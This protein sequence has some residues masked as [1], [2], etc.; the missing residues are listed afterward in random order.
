MPNDMMKVFSFDTG[1]E[2][3]LRQDDLKSARLPDRTASLL[4]SEDHPSVRLN[5]LF[6]AASLDRRILAFLKPE[7]QDKN[8]LIPARYH[9]I[10]REVQERLKKEAEKR[11]SGKGGDT[12]E[13][14][15]ELLEEEKELMV[16]L[17]T[18]RNLLHQG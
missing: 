7:L 17:D 10:L 16:L 11:K 14:A 9:A 3:I 5:E 4:P 6:R 12:L 18:Y 13:S 1:I 2:Q 15:A 8:I